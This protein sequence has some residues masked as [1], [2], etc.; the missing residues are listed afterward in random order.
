M[1]AQV[2]D[3]VAAIGSVSAAIGAV[4]AAAFE[5]RPGEAEFSPKQIVA[6]LASANDFYLMIIDEALASGFGAVRLSQ[7]PPGVSRVLATHADM[8]KRTTVAEALDGFRYASRRL[9]DALERLTPEQLDRPFVLDDAL[10]PDGGRETTT[11]RRRIVGRCA[12]HLREH[13]AQLD[14]TLALWR[15][16]QAGA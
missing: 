5:W 12:E 7:G 15:R 13:H 10:Q 11:L 8:N 16:S 3:L 9:L 2:D 6:H 4:P 1:E 14:E